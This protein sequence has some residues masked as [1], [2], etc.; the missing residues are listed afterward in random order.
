MDYLVNI[1][2]SFFYT[3]HIFQS[4]MNSTKRDQTVHC[5]GFICMMVQVFPDVIC[6]LLGY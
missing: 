2:Y 5:L 3:S 6:V 1:E 4:N